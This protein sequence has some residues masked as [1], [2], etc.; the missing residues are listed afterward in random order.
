MNEWLDNVE[1][2][3]SSRTLEEK[4]AE[5]RPAA[6]HD[7]CTPQEASEELVQEV[8]IPGVGKVCEAPDVETK[9]ATPRVVAG[10]AISTDDMEC[11]LKPLEQSAY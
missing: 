10:E 1:A 3:T 5:D 4:I 11:Q 9:F 2:D 7:I 6:A 8:E